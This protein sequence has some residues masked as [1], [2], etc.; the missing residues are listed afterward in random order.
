VS[1]GKARFTTTRWSLVQAA[2]AGESAEAD[3]ALA[4]LC[5]SYWYPL[6]VYLR[7]RGHDADDAQDLTQ[8]FFVRLI[9]KR[10]LRHADPARGRFRSFLLTSLKHFAVNEWE[11]ERAQKRGGGSPPLSLDL[12]RAEHWFQREPSTNETP[13]RL[14]DRAWALTL[15]DHAMTRLRADLERS[16]RSDQIERLTGYLMD[17]HPQRYAETASELGM[18]EGAVKV[19]VHRLRRHF[20]DLV[21]QE[22]AQTVSSSEE[23]DDELRHLLRAVAR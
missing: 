14:F 17:D 1:D 3:Q 4:A 9:E 23:L 6:Y 19:A 11:R 8:A 21:R 15:L 16:G 10:A 22:I 5:E 18:S 12:E 2:A 7:R 13:E 20:R